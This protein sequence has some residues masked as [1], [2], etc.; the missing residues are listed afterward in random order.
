[1]EKLISFNLDHGPVNFTLIGDAVNFTLNAVNEPAEEGNARL[2][3]DGSYRL[4]EDDSYR[5]L[6]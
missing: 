1:M 4:L 2:L 6:E 3:E 5:L